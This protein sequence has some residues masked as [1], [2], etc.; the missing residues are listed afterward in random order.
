MMPNNIQL[1]G[2]TLL[3]VK[4]YA[5]A[6]WKVSHINDLPRN[7]PVKVMAWNGHS[8]RVAEASIEEPDL[9]ADEL[10]HEVYKVYV[11]GV[12]QRCSGSCKWPVLKKREGQVSLQAKD[13][14][15]GDHVLVHPRFNKDA[16]HNLVGFQGFETV[17]LAGAKFARESGS[18]VTL[19][20]AGGGSIL[21]GNGVFCG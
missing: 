1:M 2:S 16:L 12:R 7:V 15:A 3:V 11:N 17:S 19:T 4:P 13:L 6:E 14:K 5:D 21:L 8:V 20:V 10:E 18:M 9:A